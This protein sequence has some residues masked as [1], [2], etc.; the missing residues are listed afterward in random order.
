MSPWKGNPGEAAHS[1]NHSSLDAQTIGWLQVLGW[2]ELHSELQASQVCRGTESQ[3][4][5][6]GKGQKSVNFSG[7]TRQITSVTFQKSPL[8][9][10]LKIAVL[11]RG[12]HLN[13]EPCK[14]THVGDFK[15]Y[16]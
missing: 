11:G 14:Q 13:R 16:S 9:V 2:P 6:V 1:C 4:A 10:S 7:R 5:K 3:R 12:Q 15:E 8:R